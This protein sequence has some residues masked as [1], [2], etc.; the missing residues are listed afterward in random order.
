MTEA[1]KKETQ[2][3][4]ESYI[5]TCPRCN[6]SFAVYYLDLDCNQLIPQVPDTGSPFYCVYCGV[7]INN[8]E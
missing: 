1:I 4:I 6:M 8:K 5:T 7:D 3:I 2:L